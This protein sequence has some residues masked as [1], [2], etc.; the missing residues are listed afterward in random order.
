[1]GKI[2]SVLLLAVL[3]TTPVYSWPP[4]GPSFEN[5]ALLS[6]PVYYPQVFNLGGGAYLPPEPYAAAGT[7]PVGPSVLYSANATEDANQDV[8]PSVLS[9]TLDDTDY[10]ITAFTKYIDPITARNYFSTTSD[11]MT[12]TQGELPMPDG[13]QVSANAVLGANVLTTGIAPG[14]IYCAGIVFNWVPHVPPNGIAVWHSDDGGRSWSA[15][16]IVSRNDSSNYFLD[17]PHIGVSW[18]SGTVGYVYVAYTKYNNSDLSQNQLL[19]SRS[20]DGGLTF[21]DPVPV[22]SGKIAN[23]QILVNP[24]FGYAIYALW[25]DFSAN[26]IQMS[27]SLDYG[28]TWEAPQTAAA[29][30][31]IAGENNFWN[32]SDYLNGDLR[33]IT[34]PRARF[35]WVKNK[36]C[37]V[38]HE[39]E[40]PGSNATDVFYTAKSFQGWQ[41]KVRVN[42]V[43]T[44]DQFMPAL[45]F[46][47]DGN[48]KVIFYDRRDDPDN[49]L[50]HQYIA[51]ID[52]NGNDLSPNERVSTFQSNPKGYR[53]HFIGDY[54]DIWDWTFSSGEK[55]HSA[56]VGIGIPA[57]TGDVYLSGI[58]PHADVLYTLATGST[59]QEGCV[60]PCMC[61]VALSE[62]MTGTFLLVPAGSDPL[63]THYYLNDISWTVLDSDGRIVHRITGQGTYKLGGEVALTH[64]LVL[65]INIDGGGIQHFDSGLIS[66]GSE[67][68]SFS[69]LV[70]RGTSC[71]NIWMD[72]KASSPQKNGSFIAAP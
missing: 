35:N 27:R 12:F 8:S 22:I 30:N 9:I 48:L 7:F 10:T 1:M 61:P 23:P 69:I 38:W 4:T 66:G 31:M 34:A 47:S 18:A 55:Y 32:E 25:V 59:F 57:N 17:R 11:F 40:Q 68:P 19:V 64:Q 43:Q 41:A 37:V 33:A 39:R 14:R 54:Q 13:Y 28:K 50:Y 58:E 45:D 72:I 51:H 62:A 29:G 21:E 2:L 20:T 56:W 53:D 65:D 5:I 6:G 63:F 71:F 70:S 42:D 24:F 44:N 49:L 46:D 16:A 26:E 67:F 60:A 3:S 36:I 52:S 15:P